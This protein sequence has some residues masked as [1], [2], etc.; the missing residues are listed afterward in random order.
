[1]ARRF[2]ESGSGIK[3]QTANFEVPAGELSEIGLKLIEP[4]PTKN[5]IYY[6]IYSEGENLKYDKNSLEADYAKRRN[7]F[8]NYQ[9][10]LTNCLNH[11]EA[12]KS[13]DEMSD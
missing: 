5:D 11:I 8:Y 10:L 13:P 4:N 9:R 7:Q 3:N 2:A 1:M 12:G 6:N